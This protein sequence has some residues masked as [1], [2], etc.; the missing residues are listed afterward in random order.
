VVD[1]LPEEHKADVK[2]KAI[3]FAISAVLAINALNPASVP[4][5]LPGFTLTVGGSGFTLGAIVNWNGSPL[6]TT[7]QDS[8]HLIATV[9]ANLITSAGTARITL[10]AVGAHRLKCGSMNLFG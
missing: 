4:A 6:S 5:G 1:H 10:N 9:P 7:L 2:R 3:D 8:A